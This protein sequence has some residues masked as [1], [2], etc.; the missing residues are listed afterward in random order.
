MHDHKYHSYSASLYEKLP[1]GCTEVL[2][3]RKINH[4]HYMFKKIKNEHVQTP[5]VVLNSWSSSFQVTCFT[6]LHNII[7][8]FISY[9]IHHHASSKTVLA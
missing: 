3:Q 2:L 7:L 1:Y 6:D 4:I 9:V 8:Y 5:C